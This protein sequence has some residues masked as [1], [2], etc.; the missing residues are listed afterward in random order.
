[1]KINFDLEHWKKE[2]RSVQCE[3]NNPT[4]IVGGHLVDAKALLFKGLSAP[5]IKSVEVS[6][7]SWYVQQI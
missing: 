5:W 6:G 7:K 1:M 3:P 4:L 2:Q